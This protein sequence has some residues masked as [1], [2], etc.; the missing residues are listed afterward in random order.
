MRKLLHLAG[1]SALTAAALLAPVPIAPCQ[2][3]DVCPILAMHAA[4]AAHEH[5]DPPPRLDCC[6]LHPMP[7]AEDSGPA[8]VGQLAAPAGL[9]ARAAAAVPAPPPPRPRATPARARGD[10]PIPLYTLHSTLLI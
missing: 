4:A 10:G 5:C 7:S 3:A 8:G 6:L 1:L 2:A 9:P